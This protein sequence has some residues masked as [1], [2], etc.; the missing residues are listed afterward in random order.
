MTLSCLIGC[1]LLGPPYGAQTSE[2]AKIADFEDAV[3]FAVKNYPLPAVS[4]FCLSGQ[5]RAQ[6]RCWLGRERII[7]S[8]DMGSGKTNRATSPSA[9]AFTD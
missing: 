5:V 8:P 6:V 4:R 9:T 1:V 2:A 3:D 7:C